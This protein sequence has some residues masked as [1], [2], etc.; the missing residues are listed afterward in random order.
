MNSCQESDL[1][2]ENLHDAQFQAE[3]ERHD[4]ILLGHMMLPSETVDLENKSWKS[5][6][7]IFTAIVSFLCWQV[8]YLTVWRVLNWVVAILSTVAWKALK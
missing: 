8:A 6:V 1:N 5:I 3:L 2:S 4:T 7:M